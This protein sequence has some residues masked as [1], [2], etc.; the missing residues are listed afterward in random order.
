M[1]ICGTLQ[2]FQR[3]QH[4]IMYTYNAGR[5]LSKPLGGCT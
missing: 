3:Q 2:T 4:I 1:N 5:I